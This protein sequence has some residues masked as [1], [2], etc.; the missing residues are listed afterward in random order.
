MPRWTGSAPSGLTR[1]Q[2]L[3]TVFAWSL[4]GVTGR[5]GHAIAAPGGQPARCAS[6]R[7]ASACSPTPCCCPWPWRPVRRCA[8]QLAA[9]GARA[10]QRAATRQDVALADVL[11]GWDAAAPARPF[12][13]LFVLENTDFGGTARCPAAPAAPAVVGPA[14]GQVPDDGL[15]GRAPRRRSTAVG[16]RRGPIH[17]DEAVGRWPRCSG[18]A[19]T[20]C[21]RTD[22]APPCAELVRPY[23][24]TLPEPGR[25]PVRRNR[26]SPRSPR[27]SPGR[28]ART[29]DAP[30]VVTADLRSLQLRR[31]RRPRRG[32][33]RGAG[34]AATRCRPTAGR[35]GVALYLDPSVEHVVALLAL[36]RLNVTAVPL[37]PAYPP[38]LLR[39]V[40][41]PGRRRCACWWRRGAGRRW[42][43]SHPTAGHRPVILVV[44][45]RHRR[46]RRRT[47]AGARTGARPL[48]T[49]FTSGSTGVPKG[50]QVSDR[51]LCDLLQWQSG[52]GGLTAPAA[53]QQFSMLAF[54]VSFQEIFGTLCTGGALHLVR[55]EWR[56][57]VPALLERLESAARERI[58]MPYVALQ[59]L[60]EYARPPGQ[61]PLAAAR[62]GHRGRAAGVHRRIR[63][64]FA[65]LP[66]ARLFNHYGP[67]ETHVVSAPVPGGRPGRV[68]RAAR[69]RTAGGRR[70]ACAW[71]TRPATAVPPGAPASC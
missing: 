55:P 59:L 2:V 49:L 13:F 57:D 9:H 23:R 7:T 28:S 37:D 67:T 1:F 20:R 42:T 68:A 69:H 43:R 46:A 6:S 18:G 40:L 5:P 12:D 45:G 44:A 35:A 58:F 51:T 41:R 26:A 38:T 66:G 30:A 16:V 32:P 63:R 34:P 54:D 21:V 4:Y 25:G 29:P 24:R 65:G 33:R 11:T 62:G 22:P 56:Q 39:Q 15:G 14:G 8:T 71:W 17:R 19:W 36:A 50:V 27:A 3:L 52:P 48:Y 61:V 31:A 53:T 10:R 64:W 60:A 47:A 70:R